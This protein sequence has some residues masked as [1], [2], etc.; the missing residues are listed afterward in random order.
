MEPEFPAE[1]ESRQK[2]WGSS[3]PPPPPHPGHSSSR[4]LTY[5]S[6]PVWKETAS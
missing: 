4:A 6:S 2:E 5:S 3:Y 1:S